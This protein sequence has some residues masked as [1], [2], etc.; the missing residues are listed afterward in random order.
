MYD[1]LF[2]IARIF[3]GG[4]ME[5][6]DC[7]IIVADIYDNGTLLHRADHLAV[8]H[9]FFGLLRPSNT[10]IYDIDLR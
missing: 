7:T 6:L 10:I 4:L 1:A 3:M 2:D 8:D 9:V 5:C